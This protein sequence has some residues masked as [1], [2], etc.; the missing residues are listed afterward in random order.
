MRSVPA[1]GPG[2]AVT[3]NVKGQP[4]TLAVR[5]VDLVPRTRFL[6]SLCILHQALLPEKAPPPLVTEIAGKAAVTELANAGRAPF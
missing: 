5:R 2:C 4:T 6:P 1:L 3:P